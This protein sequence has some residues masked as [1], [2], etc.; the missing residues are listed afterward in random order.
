MPFKASTRDQEFNPENK[1][2]H[3]F[4][5][6]IK[7]QLTDWK[8]SKEFTGAILEVMDSCCSATIRLQLARSKTRRIFVAY[9]T[10][11]P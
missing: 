1:I 11:K 6:D 4:T 8:L 9:A 5:T 7:L 3:I 10:P 2:T